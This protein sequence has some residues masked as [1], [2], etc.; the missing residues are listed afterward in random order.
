[1]G[2][3]IIIIIIIIIT[4]T[5]IIPFFPSYLLYAKI[6]VKIKRHLFTDHS[7]ARFFDSRC[8]KQRKEKNGSNGLLRCRSCTVRTDVEN[9]SSA[10]SLSSKSGIIIT[11]STSLVL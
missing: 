3:I 4:T 9:R 6:I 8:I 7:V 10:S 11:S 1:M 2:H 5:T